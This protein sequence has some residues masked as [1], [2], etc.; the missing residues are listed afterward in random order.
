MF[1]VSLTYICEMSD[2]EKYLDEHI[3]Y[4]DN[5]Y[6]LGHFIASGRKVPRVGGVIL[7]TVDSVDILNKILADDPFNKHGL[8]EYDVIEFIPTKTA[9]ELDFLR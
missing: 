7:A 6:K 4:L 8:A 9:K 5:Q 1:V 3:K 2:V